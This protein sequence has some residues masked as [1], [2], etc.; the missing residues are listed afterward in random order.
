MPRFDRDLWRLAGRLA[1]QIA[2]FYG[3]SSPVVLEQALWF[4]AQRML[5]Q[6]N[7]LSGRNWTAAEQHV[8]RQFLTTVKRL[9][10]GLGRIIREMPAGGQIPE[11][12]GQRQIYEDLLACRDEFD[13]FELDLRN[14]TL[15][16]TTS[17]ITLEG[18]SFGRFQIRADLRSLV[19][20]ASYQVIAKTPNRPST[21]S[22]ITHPHVMDDGLCEG[23]AAGPLACAM[24]TGR[25]CDFFEIIQQTLRTYNAE[26]AYASISAWNDEIQCHACGDTVPEYDSRYCDHCAA[27]VCEDCGESCPHCGEAACGACLESCPACEESSCPSCLQCCWRCGNRR[28]PDCLIEAHC[29]KCHAIAFPPAAATVSSTTTHAASEAPVFTDSL[30]QAALP[31]GSG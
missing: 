25:L 3:A 6:L 28:C 15:S 5:S 27:D 26:S 10:D 22:D 18:I 20:G 14:Q 4:R 16:V 21:R 9:Y 31:E 24:R 2:R 8:R 17:E 19:S 29:E 7:G 30:G 23:D 11:P 13:N 1:N 12:P